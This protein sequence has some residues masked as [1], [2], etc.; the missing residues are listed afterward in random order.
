MEKELGR[1]LNPDEVVHHINGNRDD[2]RIENLE[3]WLKGHPQGQRLADRLKWA[4]ELLARY[5]K[6]LPKLL[7]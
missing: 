1:P 7:P 3:I 6:E 5:E 2:N 4:Q